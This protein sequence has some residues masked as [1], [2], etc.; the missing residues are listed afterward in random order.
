MSSRGRIGFTSLD[1]SAVSHQEN[2]VD[3]RKPGDPG[4]MGDDLRVYTVSYSIAFLQVSKKAL[5]LES[6]GELD[7]LET[8]VSHA[9]LAGHATVP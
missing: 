3:D 4:P 7:R 9:Y 8:L 6:F 1:D 2:L 5:N